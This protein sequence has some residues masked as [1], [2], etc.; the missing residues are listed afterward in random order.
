M[1]WSFLKQLTEL[2]FWG[3]LL[4]LAL[5]NL[6]GTVGGLDATGKAGYEDCEQ[7][8]LS[9]ITLFPFIINRLEQGPKVE[10]TAEIEAAEGASWSVRRR[11][12]S[13][14]DDSN[15]VVD[16]FTVGVAQGTTTTSTFCPANEMFSN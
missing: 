7:T 15:F 14:T 8:M 13:L 3:L 10:V 4:L 11:S 12:S 2:T 5:S 1:V 16:E 9:G 6:A